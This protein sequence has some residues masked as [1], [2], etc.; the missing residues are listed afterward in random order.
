MN[1]HLE[2]QVAYACC[3]QVVIIINSVVFLAL[4]FITVPLYSIGVQMGSEFR[5]HI[6]TPDVQTWALDTASS[7]L[8]KVSSTVTIDQWSDGEIYAHHT[9]CCRCFDLHELDCFS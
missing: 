9:V 5:P 7:K 3:I 1:S 2:S 4:S 8:S 6:S